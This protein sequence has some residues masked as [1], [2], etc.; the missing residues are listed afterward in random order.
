M[1]SL[2]KTL[3]LGEKEKGVLFSLV[4]VFFLSLKGCTQKTGVAFRMCS[5]KIMDFFLSKSDHLTI[6]R[7]SQ[8]EME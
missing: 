2:L 5:V 4:L 3:E 7:S 1:R 8:H 6:R